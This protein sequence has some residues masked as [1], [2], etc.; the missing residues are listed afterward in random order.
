MGAADWDAA[1]WDVAEWGFLG[2][3]GACA[4]TAIAAGLVF[5]AAGLFRALRRAPAAKPGFALERLAEA[6]PPRASPAR[7]ASI[8]SASD[9][10]DAL[11]AKAE[12]A[13]ASRAKRALDVAAALALLVLFAPLIA[14]AAVLIRLDSPGPVLYRQRRVG[15]HGRV[16]Q[17]LKLRTMTADAEKEGP[18]WAA[19]NDGR[20]T[21]VGRILRKTRFDE[22]PQAINVLRGEMSMVGPR[23][24]RPEFVRLLEREIPDYRLRHAVRPGLTGWAQV[25]YVYGASVEDARV[26]LRFDLDY[27]RRFAVRF[28]VVILLMTVRVALFGLGSR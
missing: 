17:M 16:F 13:T 10:A 28:D 3:A 15:L 26:K 22:I 8:R 1:D 14:L 12:R 5:L 27:I 2:W 7:R 6:P 11:L 20:V 23:P 21:R 25:K 18:C 19:Q 9:A 4:A 24:E